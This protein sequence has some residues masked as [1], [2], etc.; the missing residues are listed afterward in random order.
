MITRV[1]VAAAVLALAACGGGRA[2]VTPPAAASSTVDEAVLASWRWQAARRHLVVVTVDPRELERPVED[3]QLDALVAAPTPELR[4]AV[5]QRGSD[6]PAQRRLRFIVFRHEDDPAATARAHERRAAARA[7][8]EHGESF[9]ALARELSEDPVAA[10]RGGDVGWK[11]R[12]DIAEDFGDAVFSAAPGTVVDA[13][14][15]RASFL[16]SVE[17]ARIGPLPAAV[18]L[19]ETAEQLLRRAN[20]E[21]IA[22]RC[23]EQALEDLRAARPVADLRAALDATCPLPP[24]SASVRVRE[25]ESAWRDSLDEDLASTGTFDYSYTIADAAFAATLSAP[26]VGPL[27]LGTKVVAFRL[28]AIVPPPA[29]PRPTV[30]ERRCVT[31]RLQATQRDAALAAIADPGPRERA[32]IARCPV[33]GPMCNRCVLETGLGPAR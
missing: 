4:A 15:P 32:R 1:G 5:A 13:D 8:L 11:A 20:R 25:I 18:V 7:R 16:V 28:V 12:H 6:V 31:E 10:L 2:P 27:E 14:S 29:P 33:Q 21:A 26:V 23:V 24:R 22:R 9:A 3:T 30:E 17:A 19:R